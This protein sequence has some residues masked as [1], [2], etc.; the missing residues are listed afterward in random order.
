[1]A[2]VDLFSKMTK[3]GGTYDKFA[4]AGIIGQAEKNEL[5]KKALEREGN[6]LQAKKKM[7]TSDTKSLNILKKIAEVSKKT[8]AGM[9][10]AKS[11]QGEI[12]KQDEVIE[13]LRKKRATL[14]DKTEKKLCDKI[15]LRKR[16]ELE[17]N[18]LVLDQTRR[19][20]PL[21]GSMG[22]VGAMISD[23]L[24]TVFDTIGNIIPV[25]GTVIAG[26]LKLGGAI[27]TILM[28]PLKTFLEIQ[29]TVGNLAADIGLTNAESRNLLVNMGGLAME[30]SKFGGNMKDVAEVM[31]TFSN[32][33]GKNRLFSKEEIGSIVELGLGTGLGVKGASQLAASFDNIGLSLKKTIDL[34]SK[35]RDIAAKYN[36]NTTKVL[37]TYQGLVQSLTGIGFG[38][39]LEN[40]AKLAAKAEAIRFD[41]VKSTQS[42]T[43]SFFNPEKAVEASAQMQ[44]LGGKFAQSFGDPM[45]L[46]FESMNDPAALAEKFADTVKGIVKKDKSGNFF[47]PPQ[48]R[49][50]LQIAAQSLGQNYDEIKTS[51][52]EQAKIADK[53]TA[54][55]NSGF[56][57]LGLKE[58]DRLAVSGL[59]KLNEKGQYVIKN[60]AGVDKLLSEM[61]DKNQLNEIINSRKKNDDAAIQRKNLMERLSLIADRFTLGF[62]SVMAK[63]FG[64]QDFESFLQMIEKVGMQLA[65]FITNDLMGNK[66]LANQFKEILDNGRSAFMAIVDIFKDP[67]KGIGTKI[68]EAL[69]KVLD[70]LV[71][72]LL[73]KIIETIAPFFA[74]GFGSILR[75]M[76]DIPLI[77][78]SLNQKGVNM[79]ASAIK[80]DKSGALAG[81]FTD[82]NGNS[83]VQDLMKQVRPENKD[84]SVFQGVGELGNAGM[85]GTYLA[86]NDGSKLLS[87][88]LTTGGKSLAFKGGLMGGKVGGGLA[89]GGLGVMKAGGKLGLETIFKRIPII[90]SLLSA[91]FAISDWMSGD[92]TGAALQGASAIANL[93]P[94][95]G[96][97]ISMGLDAGDAAR[98]LGAF[99]DGVIYKDGAYAKFGKG[100]MVSFM[101]QDSVERNGSGGGGSAMKVEHG[102][103]ITIKSDDGKV[104][105][106]EQMYNARDL[107]G[108]RIASINSG[109][110]GGF[111]N[112]QNPNI[113]PIKPLM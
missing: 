29:S 95:I 39:G 88:M 81:M 94:G 85:K 109:Y 6:I 113:S 84:H 17:T 90:G 45:T 49:K 53:M 56:N 52:I 21:F 43:D 101:D 19:T 73:S 76:K 10:T 74:A 44:V 70:I 98:N 22:K 25:I 18:K 24:V 67:H 32:V 31:N 26:L 13:T 1:M 48:D 75:M 58:E 93:F 106:W 34:T 91:G 12:R 47:I 42:F 99:D 71:K 38:K 37:T 63:L 23:T 60:S 33:T 30:A 80:S 110:E 35:A 96:T 54:L 112:Y 15:I 65:S 79:Q 77:G 83:T 36:L 86:A 78:K 97:A 102:G 66:G 82:D 108:G 105:T 100:D 11:I 111:G 3:G 50:M 61:T 28:A 46:A 55:S 4:N 89:K 9:K 104:V 69:S 68:G 20:I 51:A 103:V 7:L 64:S 5:L 14:I 16:L 62:S 40:L 92:Y 107:I 87:K 41:L 59:M 57:I 2:Q 72:P 27:I 8:Y